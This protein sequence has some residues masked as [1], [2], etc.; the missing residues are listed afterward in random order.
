MSAKGWVESGRQIQL[1]DRFSIN[2]PSKRLSINK[3]PAFK[4]QA[5]VR[6]TVYI[7]WSS[8]QAAWREVTLAVIPSCPIRC[9][10]GNSC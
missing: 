8:M 7:T 10:L 4:V 9:F 2:T 6:Q 3:I 1:L 5:S